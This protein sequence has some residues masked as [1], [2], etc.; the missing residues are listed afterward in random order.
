MRKALKAAIA[1][2]II[3]ICAMCFMP[4]MLF[5]NF[6]AFET[7]GIQHFGRITA[8]LTPANT[9]VHLGKIPTIGDLAVIVG[10]NLAN[11]FLL[12]PLVLG[13]L[14]LRKNQ[15]SL[16][17]VVLMTFCISLTIELTQ[18]VLDL[19][20]D[21]NRVFEVDDLITN[22]LGGVI[23]YFINRGIKKYGIFNFK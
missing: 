20:F 1:V 4:Q 5:P 9:L 10:Q 3:A 16:A 8:I 13:L 7:P 11:I 23:A 22:T 2:Y 17:K 12:L 19:L 14:L 18:V 6:K 15:M 21:F